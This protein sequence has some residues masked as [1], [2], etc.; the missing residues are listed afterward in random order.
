V[1]D[2]LSY[3]IGSHIR[4]LAGEIIIDIRQQQGSVFGY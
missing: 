2:R 1:G 3:L 4:G